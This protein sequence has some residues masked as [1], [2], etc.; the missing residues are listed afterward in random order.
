M[1]LSIQ[2]KCH[3]S[4]PILDNGISLFSYS[5]NKNGDRLRDQPYLPE[6]SSTSLTDPNYQ[7]SQGSNLVSITETDAEL[8]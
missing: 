1:I 4:F 5:Y 2:T 8:K 7:Q 6:S 3:Y